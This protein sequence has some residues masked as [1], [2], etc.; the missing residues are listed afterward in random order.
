MIRSYDD[1]NRNIPR[2]FL[3]SPREPG[4]ANGICARMSN[5]QCMLSHH[6]IEQLLDRLEWQSVG[7]TRGFDPVVSC[8]LF[9]FWVEPNEQFEQSSSDGAEVQPYELFRKPFMME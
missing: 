2:V 1:L 3:S 5:S 4:K 9:A 6:R 8:L 7:S